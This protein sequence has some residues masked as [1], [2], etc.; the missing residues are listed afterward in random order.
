VQQDDDRLAALRVEPVGIDVRLGD[1][2]A[3][4]GGR[5]LTAGSQHEAFDSL[6]DLRTPRQAGEA[7]VGIG[8]IRPSAY[9]IFLVRCGDGKVVAPALNAV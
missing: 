6:G 2:L 1:R 3:E 4:A 9:V 5:R 7:V 8:M